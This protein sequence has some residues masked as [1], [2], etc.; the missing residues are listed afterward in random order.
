MGN[1]ITKSK[2]TQ[3]K[4]AG[5]KSI[6]KVKKSKTSSSKKADLQWPLKKNMAKASVGMKV[7]KKALVQCAAAVEYICAEVLELTGNA[8]KDNKRTTMK[9]RHL[10]M[11][12]RDD[13]ELSQMIKGVFAQGGVLPNLNAALLPKRK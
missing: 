11:A 5:R 12:V 9:P 6:S 7:S 13:P 2:N 8:A 10:M 4:M 1:F 3:T